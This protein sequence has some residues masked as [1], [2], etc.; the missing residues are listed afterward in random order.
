MD[1]VSEAAGMKVLS[2]AHCSGLRIRRCYS[3]SSSLDSNSGPGTLY[4]VG[5]PKKKKR[6]KERKKKRP[7]IV[8]VGEVMEKKRTCA[9]CW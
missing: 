7:E 3:C 5:W 2:L 4:A 6:K 8:S 9:L 1:S